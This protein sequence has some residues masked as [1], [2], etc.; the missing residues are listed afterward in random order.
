MIIIDVETTGS[1]IDQPEIYSIIDL[2]A[3]DFNKPENF[4]H[5]RCNVREGAD[6]DPKALMYNGF[7]LDQIND[8]SLPELEDILLDFFKWVENIEDRTPAGQNV[9]FDLSFLRSSCKLYDFDCSII[10]GHRKVDLHS[11]VYASKLKKDNFISVIDGYSGINSDE[12]M[13]YVGIPVEPKPHNSAL[14]GVIWEAEAFNRIIYGKP[15]V[16]RLNDTCKLYET[17]N[18][19]NNYDVPHYLLR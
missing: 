8:P 12:V 5:S 17:F 11:L 18:N 6:I 7:T 16:C 2:A 19:F 3:M 14:N 1:G 13:N 9:D 4:F 10:F 15:L